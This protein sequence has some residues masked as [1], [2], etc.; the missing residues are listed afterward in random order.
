VSAPKLHF[1]AVE[2]AEGRLMFTDSQKAMIRGLLKGLPAPFLQVTFQR[3]FRPRTT[4]RYSQG[5]RVNGHCAVIAEATG[6]DFDVVKI[7]MKQLAIARGW[8]FVTVEEDINGVT[9]EYK[10]AKS[11]ASASV[12]EDSILCQVIE[13]YAAEHGIRLPERGE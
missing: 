13:Q 5:A 3:P 7:R 1:P 8:P 4:G 2:L 6:D 11:E 12:D 10:V 9:H